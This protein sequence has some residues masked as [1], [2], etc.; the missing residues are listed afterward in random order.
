M[1]KQKTLMEAYLESE[2]C[3]PEQEL[4]AYR[5]KYGRLSADEIRALNQEAKK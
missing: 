4:A 5:I 3:T 2:S 1:K